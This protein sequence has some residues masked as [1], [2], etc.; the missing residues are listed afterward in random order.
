MGTAALHWPAS[1]NRPCLS[2][3]CTAVNEYKSHFLPSG[4]SSP[5]I[6]FHRKAFFYN[7]KTVVLPASTCYCQSNS[8]LVSWQPLHRERKCWCHYEAMWLE[9]VSKQEQADGGRDSFWRTSFR[10][11]NHWFIHQYKIYFNVD[12][13]EFQCF[14]CTFIKCF[15]CKTSFSKLLES[16]S[17]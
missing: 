5:K 14:I 8:H 7:W 6:P 1:A 4:T 2:L 3:T 13:L 16:K 15:A 10:V 11:I 17:N 9:T 12:D